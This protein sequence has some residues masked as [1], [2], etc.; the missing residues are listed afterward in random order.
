MLDAFQVDEA[1]NLRRRPPTDAGDEAVRA[2][3]AL[4]LGKRLL[5][6]GCVFGTLDDRSER[7][8]HVE[9]DGRLLGVAA[10]AD[11]QDG[12]AHIATL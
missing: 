6:H 9:E 3:Q 10:E 7:P 12:G 2:R 1:A 5:R 11:E 4:D 8:V